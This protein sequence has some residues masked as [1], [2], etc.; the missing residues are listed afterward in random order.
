[1]S[2]TAHAKDKDTWGTLWG[3][4]PLAA[5]DQA[6]LDRDAPRVLELAWALEDDATEPRALL[7][8]LFLEGLAGIVDLQFDEEGELYVL[9]MSALYRVVAAQP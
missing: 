1:M 3:S 9:T 5:M 8:A 4:E 2:V 6:W 7:R